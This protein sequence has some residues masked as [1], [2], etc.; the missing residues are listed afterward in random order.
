[1]YDK[2]TQ[3]ELIRFTSVDTGST[4]ID[5]YPGEGDWTRLFSDIV[6]SEGTVYTFV[7]AEVADFKND[8]V[9]QMLTLASEP[10]RE[11]SKPSRPI[12][13]R[14]RRSRSRRMSCGCTSSTTIF[15]PS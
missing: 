6:G 12:L 5:V 13:W 9:G 10:G 7:P 2:T 3:S 15:T 1:M 14:C 8:P 11:T 4:V